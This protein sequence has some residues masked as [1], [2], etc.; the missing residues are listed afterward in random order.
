MIPVCREYKKRTELLSE[1]LSQLLERQ[2]FGPRPKTYADRQ[3]LLGVYLSHLLVQ[4][5]G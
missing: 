5:P 4:D 2:R 3:F 1:P